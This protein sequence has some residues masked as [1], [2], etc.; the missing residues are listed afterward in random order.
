MEKRTE[1]TKYNQVSI[2]LVIFKEIHM[3]DNKEI[4]KFI[5]HFRNCYTKVYDM[6]SFDIYL[7]F[8][9]HYEL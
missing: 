9:L 5:T 4:V 6:A 7:A 2:Q 3:S 1:S 8:E